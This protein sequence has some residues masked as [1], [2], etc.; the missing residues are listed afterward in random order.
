[1]HSLQCNPLR[2]NPLQR[3]LATVLPLHS[4]YCSA[5][6]SNGTTLVARQRLSLSWMKNAIP[7]RQPPPAA[8]GSKWPLRTKIKEL[9]MYADPVGCELHGEAGIASLVT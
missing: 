1:M 5:Q 6:A 3:A 2:R 4:Y 9:T 7:M 8:T